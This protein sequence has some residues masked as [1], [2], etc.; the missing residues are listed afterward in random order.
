M[1]LE[2]KI[3]EK[4]EFGCAVSEIRSDGQGMARE[5][6]PSRR[7]S[8]RVIQSMAEVSGPIAIETD[9]FVD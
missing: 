6:A 7:P 8:G 1:G 9:R 5:S 3:A 4:G 2:S